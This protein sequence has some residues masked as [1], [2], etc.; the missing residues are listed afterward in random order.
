MMCVGPKTCVLGYNGTGIQLAVSLMQAFAQQRGLP[1]L[2]TSAKD[3]T[4][5]E[6]AFMNLAETIVKSPPKKR[7]EAMSLPVGES[8][9]AEEKAVKKKGCCG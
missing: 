5:V 6:Q 4:N 9:K 7:E 1:V 8:V 3:D 2:E